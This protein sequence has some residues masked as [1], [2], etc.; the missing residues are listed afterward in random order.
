MMHPTLQNIDLSTFRS[1]L[2]KWHSG[3]FVPDDAI[4]TNNL[5]YLQTEEGVFFTG[6]VF[7]E[8]GR[9]FSEY[10]DGLLDG[11]SLSFYENGA[12]FMEKIYQRGC[13]ISSIYYKPDG[14]TFNMYKPS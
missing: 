7:Y 4:Y 8:A 12:I 13:L 10:K 9:S 5:G 2:V 3:M 14:T 1:P 11:K 6:T